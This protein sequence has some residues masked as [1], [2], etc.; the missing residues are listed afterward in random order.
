MTSG[1]CPVFVRVCLQRFSS[2]GRL[3]PS[4]VVYY[5]AP[6]SGGWPVSPRAGPPGIDRTA[7]D[8]AAEERLESDCDSDSNW[9]AGGS[10]AVCGRQVFCLL[11]PFPVFIT[12]KLRSADVL[13]M[14]C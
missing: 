14:K 13:I 7:G 1:T 10:A 8:T 4:I 3:S 5:W 12:A 9:G 11:A 2:A 6:V